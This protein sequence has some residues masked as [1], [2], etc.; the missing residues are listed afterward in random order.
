[1]YTEDVYYSFQVHISIQKAPRDC[2]EG[3]DGFYSLTKVRRVGGM[4]TDGV[5]I[6]TKFFSSQDKGI[7]YFVRQRHNKAGLVHTFNTTAL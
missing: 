7:I 2:T 1:M 5:I 6:I 4:G 3:V